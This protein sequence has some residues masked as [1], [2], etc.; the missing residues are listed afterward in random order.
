M[1]LSFARVR[2][3]TTLFLIPKTTPLGERRSLRFQPIPYHVCARSTLSP[4]LLSV[5][6]L[7][8]AVQ[9]NFH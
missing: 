4:L 7:F 3:R 6:A 2:S 1:L 5:A 9:A 8:Q